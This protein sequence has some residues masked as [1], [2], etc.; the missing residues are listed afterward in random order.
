[1][2]GSRVTVLA[3]PLTAILTLHA[4]PVQIGILEAMGSAAS[5]VFA[6]PAGVWVDR[7][8][9]RPIMILAN[10][11]QAALLLTIPAAA[12]LGVL[13]LPQLYVV[14]FLSASLAVFFNVARASFLPSIVSREELVEANS[15]LSVSGS[16]AQ[17]AGP[18]LGGVLVQLLT[19]PV[20][21]LADA[22][23]FIAS[24]LGLIAIQ[25]P[26][27]PRRR[28][29]ASN[30][31]RELTEGLQV[32]RRDPIL[33]SLAGASATFNL[34][35][36]VLFAVYVLYMS[37]TLHL[38]ASTIGLVFGLAGAGGLLAALLVAP[39]TARIGVGRAILRGVVLATAGELLIAAAGGPQ[40]VAVLVLLGA[41]GAVELGAGLYSINVGS[42][43]QA[44]TPDHLRGRV[45][46]SIELVTFGVG[47]IGAVLG[48]LL[49]ETI[50][51][52]ATVMVAGAGTLLSLLWL[53]SSPIRVLR[54]MPA[55]TTAG[56]AASPE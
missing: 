17:I 39:L 38:A 18:G 5:L 15:K 49:G 8:R 10:L 34:F 9:R 24:T 28:A 14:S 36:S 50:G 43:Q 45:S 48:G 4:S 54:E 3:L 26:E 7:T 13:V 19:P 52:R 53:R 55:T 20:A 37:R 6:L 40:I 21:I 23:S 27:A 29:A 30:T 32:L 33:L 12:W 1:M 31:R 46:A 42:L 44:I 22:I 11:G 25:A 35:D 16:L 47:P 56:I 51:L 2:F 41:E